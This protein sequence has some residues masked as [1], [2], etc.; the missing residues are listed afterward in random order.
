[1]LKLLIGTLKYELVVRKILQLSVCLCDRSKSVEPSGPLLEIQGT[2][3]LYSGQR[4]Q[5]LVEKLE[6]A[7]SSGKAAG[8]FQVMHQAVRSGSP[9]P[10]FPSANIV[11]SSV[12]Y[13]NQIKTS[14]VDLSLKY[15][16]YSISKLLSIC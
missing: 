1:V 11:C 7:I 3:S 6:K 15:V 8:E 12:V 13:E 14:Q 5:D 2:S 10:M 16:Y 4:L 9:H